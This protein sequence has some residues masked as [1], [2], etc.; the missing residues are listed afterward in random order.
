MGRKVQVGSETRRQAHLKKAEQNGQKAIDKWT[1][2]LA[3]KRDGHDGGIPF[4][5]AAYIMNNDISWAWALQDEVPPPSAIAGRRDT[6][7]IANKEI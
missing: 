7:S 5:E 3:E 2:H 1:K 6:V 4:D